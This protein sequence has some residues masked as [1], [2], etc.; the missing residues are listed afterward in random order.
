MNL[1]VCQAIRERR[2]L[3]FYYDGGTRDVE[4][5]CHG[6][7]KDGNELLKGYQASGFSQSGER[8]GWKTFRLDLVRALIVSDAAFP[9]ARPGYD[10]NDARIFEVHCRL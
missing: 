9:G 3:R 10:P 8:F 4:P 2:V 5:H 1:L 6:F 7:S